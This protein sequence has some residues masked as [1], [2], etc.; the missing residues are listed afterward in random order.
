[1]RRRL[2]ATGALVLVLAACG[3]RGGGAEGANGTTLTN[4]VSAN[5]GSGGGDA[6][7][8]VDALPEG[9][10][11][12]VLIRAIR[13]AN[14]ACQ[15]VTESSLSPTSNK[16]PVYFATCEDG[17]VYAVA[18]RDDGTATVQPVTPAQ[19]R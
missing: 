14:L 2:I 17:A 1:M 18:I 13:D 9:Q 11:N 7:N 5:A 10:R 19:G 16:M 8:K 15:Q 12:G 6:Q 3:G 4:N